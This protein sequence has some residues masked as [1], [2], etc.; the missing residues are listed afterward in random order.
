MTEANDVKASLNLFKLPSVSKSAYQ[1]LKVSP[2]CLEVA[3][4]DERQSA[5]Q[6]FSIACQKSSRIPLFCLEPISL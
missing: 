2:S 6:F 5:C 4:R 3:E 1:V